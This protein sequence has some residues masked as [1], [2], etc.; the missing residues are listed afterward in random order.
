[1]LLYYI[2]DGRQLR[3]DLLAAIHRA[4]R[5]G[6]DWVQIREK[7]LSAR[8]LF[9]LTSAV[10]K[11]AP[12][13]PPK[14]FVNTR[15]D[16]ALA[17]GAHGVHLPSGSVSAAEIRKLSSPGF[18]VGVSCHHTDEVRRAASE[19]ADFVVFGP[20]FETP[21]KQAYGPPK[22]LKKLEE[23]CGA[24]D[25]PVL[26]LGGVGLGN[27]ADCLAAGAAGIAGIS[28]FQQA[29]DLAGVAAALRKLPPHAAKQ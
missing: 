15:A 25:I 19:G 26:A 16:V 21:S 24:A 17:A 10:M 29:E 13:A 18:V 12:D 22:G 5:A 9:E 1:M 28:L 8:K 20:V 11:L 14:I 6:V 2:T 7:D 27:A 23:A 3:G 4:L